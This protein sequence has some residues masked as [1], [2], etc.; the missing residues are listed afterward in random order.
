MDKLALVI[1]LFAFITAFY[2]ALEVR[3]SREWR[4]EEQARGEAFTPTQ[5]SESV[6][7]KASVHPNPALPSGHHFK[8]HPHHIHESGK[9][10]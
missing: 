2:A 8:G 5:R 10:A 3:A 1:S 7:Q 4:D 6:Y 9:P